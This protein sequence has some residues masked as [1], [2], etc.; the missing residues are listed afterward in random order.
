MLEGARDLELEPE[1]IQ[2]IEKFLSQSK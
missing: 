1:Y 2:K